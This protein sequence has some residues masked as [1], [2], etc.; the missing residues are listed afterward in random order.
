MIAA[1][2]SD[3]VAVRELRNLRNHQTDILNQHVLQGMYAGNGDVVWVWQGELQSI[4]DPAELNALLSKICREAY[5]AT[6]V[7]RNE[8]VNRNIVSSAVATARQSV[9]WGL[10]CALGRSGF[11]IQ[12]R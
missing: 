1:N 4:S 2:E 5:S 10:S 12:P 3:K 8:L 6:P 7:F 9:L 11:G